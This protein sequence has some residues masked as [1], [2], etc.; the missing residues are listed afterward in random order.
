MKKDM[1][2]KIMT[3]AVVT[4]MA[5]G[6]TA[7]KG[8]TPELKDVNDTL[9]WIMGVNVAKSLPEETFFELDKEVF[10]AAI[11][12]TLSGKQQPIDDTTMA[13]GMQFM[14]MQ[15]YA[16]QKNREKNKAQTATATQEEYFKKLVAKNKNVKKSPSGF[17]YEVLREGHGAR[18]KYAQR[19]RFDYRSYT[20][21]GKP[22]D[23]TYE[24]REPIVHVV[25]EP[26][27]PGLIEGF[28]LMNAG[29]IFRFY[30]P[31]QMLG[32]TRGS[33]SV[34]AYTP[35]IYDIELHE[36]YAD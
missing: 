7:P 32:G 12:N 35:M 19:I 22:F 24:Q 14:A 15:D 30:F 2:Y 25:G 17:Y 9:S 6:C 8:E 16:F 34:E 10:C 4:M 21:D 27:F 11:E 5:A 23:Q 18:A 1:K 31:Y 29:S 28:Q 3:L 13:Q 33:G 26:M 36:I 20:L